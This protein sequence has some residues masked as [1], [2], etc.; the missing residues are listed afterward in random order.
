[1]DPTTYKETSA[2]YIYSKLEV[3]VNVIIWVVCSELNFV[4]A[5]K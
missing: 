5:T 4:D 1:V 2:P 3:I